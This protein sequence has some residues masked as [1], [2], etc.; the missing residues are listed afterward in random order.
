MLL[1]RT[2]N[3]LRFTAKTAAH[4]NIPRRVFHQ[5]GSRFAS[6]FSL[7]FL[8]KSAAVLALAVSPII[9]LSLAARPRSVKTGLDVFEQQHFSAL[10]GKRVGVITNHTGVDRRGRSIIE[11]LARA[12]GVKLAA[13]FN[14]EHGLFGRADEK[15]S[16]TAYDVPTPNGPLHVPVHSLYG[17]TRR[18]TPEMLEGLDA[19]VFDIQDA[20]VRFYT[21]TTTMGYAME[22]AAKRHIPVYVLDRPNLM[23][24]EIIE[25]PALDRDRLSFVA[26]FPMPVRYAMTIGELARMFNA[27]NKIGCDLH[28]IAM[29]GWRRSDFYSDTGLQWIPPSPNLRTLPATLLYPGLEILQ[30]AGVSV[31]R[32]TPAPFEE[33]GAPWMRGEEVAAELNR[34]AI[35]GLRFRPMRY[36]PESGLHKGQPCEGV[37]IEILDR[38][39]VRSMRMGLEIAAMLQKLYPENFSAGRILLLVGNAATIQKLSSGMPVSEI[40]ASWAPEL[41]AFGQ[42][43]SKYLLYR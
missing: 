15:V 38:K 23:G 31:G 4:K 37:S 33:F 24:G 29:H 19:L 42:M 6:H 26:Y 13:L 30:E 34:R 5:G 1:S 28:V 35:P 25:G 11:L 22:E 40:V 20:G 41:A 9:S 3:S 2:T 7:R 18:P 16:S 14:P 8:T 36:T 27:E 39:A 21:Y 10:R 17:E 12:P 43:R 32:G